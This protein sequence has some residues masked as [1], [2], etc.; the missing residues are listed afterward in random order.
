MLRQFPCLPVLRQAI[1]SAKQR[2]AIPHYNQL[3]LAISSTIHRALATNEPVNAIIA[4]PSRGLTSI[5]RR[6]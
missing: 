4:A 3:S 1:L 5:I 6:G 2:P